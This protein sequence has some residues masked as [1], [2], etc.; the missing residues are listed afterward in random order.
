MT[1]FLCHLKVANI[2]IIEK[3]QIL[4]WSREAKP[5]ASLPTVMFMLLEYVVKITLTT[6]S[7][8]ISF[9]NNCMSLAKKSCQLEEQKVGEQKKEINHFQGT[10]RN[11]C[12]NTPFYHIQ[13]DN[14][15]V[16][17]KKNMLHNP[18]HKLRKFSSNN[19]ISRHIWGS[20]RE[21]LQG[22]M[23]SNRFFFTYTLYL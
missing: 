17:I 5:K 2:K 16:T 15:P 8:L 13:W 7:T 11:S 20:V 4:W 3:F 9:K 19:Q 14:I 21:K 23:I 18:L 6:M 10:F 12:S 22:G 1:C